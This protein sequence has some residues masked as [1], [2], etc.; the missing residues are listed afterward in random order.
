M[1]TFEE[2][3]AALLAQP[4]QYLRERLL[5][6]ADANGFTTGEL[7]ALAQTAAMAWA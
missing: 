7:E 3:K 2:Y 5:S 6:E 1:K 4:S